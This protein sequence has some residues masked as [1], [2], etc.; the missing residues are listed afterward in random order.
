MVA[1]IASYS[2]FSALFEFWGTS[3]QETE[4]AMKPKIFLGQIFSIKSVLKQQ[5]SPSEKI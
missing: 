3:Y 5:V 4:K 1:K 2:V